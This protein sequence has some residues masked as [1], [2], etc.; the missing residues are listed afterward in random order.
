MK[1]IIKTGDK[2]VIAALLLTAAVLFVLSLA[3]GGEAGGTAVVSVA[4]EEY[5][6]LPLSADTVYT[7]DTDGGHN[8]IVV[9]G[10]EVFMQQADCPDG[11]CM[12]QGSVS[13]T[14]EVIVCLPN[15]VTVTV[16]G[17]DEGLDA[18]VG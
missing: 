11:H 15:R 14:G 8:V 2:V 1:D 12:A 18:V 4:G 5:A 3:L 9:S 16:E 6:R 10:G 13:R 17:A 7:V